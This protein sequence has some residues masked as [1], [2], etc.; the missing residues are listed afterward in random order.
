MGQWAIHIEGSGIHD[1]GKD[2]DADAMLRE[3]V[4]RLA[5]AGQRVQSATLT[6]GSTRE[7]TDARNQETGRI[8]A[9]S[10]YRA[11]AH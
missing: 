8:E 2:A 4:D 7:L 10:A 6:V 11:R 5:V 9:P 3:F 1:N